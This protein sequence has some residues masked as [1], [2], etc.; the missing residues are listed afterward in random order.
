MHIDVYAYLCARTCA[1]A[2][3][4]VHTHTHTRARARTHPCMYTCICR[5]NI[6]DRYHL[7]THGL[8]RHRPAALRTSRCVGLFARAR[9]CSPSSSGETRALRV[10]RGG[11]LRVRKR[12][13]P[14]LVGCAVAHHLPNARLGLPHRVTSPLRTHKTPLWRANVEHRHVAHS[15][16][17]LQIAAQHAAMRRRWH[18]DLQRRAQL[19]EAHDPRSTAERPRCARGLGCDLVL[20]RGGL[21]PARRGGTGPAVQHEDRSTVLNHMPRVTQAARVQRTDWGRSV[22]RAAFALGRV[23]GGGARRSGMGLVVRSLCV[24]APAECSSRQPRCM[25]YV[26][27]CMP[28]DCCSSYVCMLPVRTAADQP[29]GVRHRNAKHN[30]KNGAGTE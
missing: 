11:V 17:H 7:T 27:C 21:E 5:P 24:T 19:G 4:N 22:V 6:S 9:V 23:A 29:V 30:G 2:R 14:H 28:G 3:V 20:R 8:P 1:C 15:T 16:Q 12:E 26:A 18:S 25:L 10:L 13:A